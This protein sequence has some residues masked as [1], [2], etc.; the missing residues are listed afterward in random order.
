[1]K[2]IIQ[3]CLIGFIAIATLTACEKEEVVNPIKENEKKAEQFKAS[4]SKEGG[5]VVTKFYA[6]KPI[7]YVTTDD[8]VN[9]E[10]DLNKYIFPH[11]LDDRNVLKPNGTLEIHQNEIKK[12]L[13]DSAVLY[14]TW[15]I[16]SNRNGVFFEFVDEHYSQRRYKLDEFNDAYFI[17]YLDWPVD[18][19]K[20]FSR[21][22]FK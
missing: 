21:F 8:I 5:F 1:M 11:L 13:N 7:D 22:D 20:I 18:G 6:D 9:L 2:L 15:N 19:A 4:V 12:P 16:F 14:R 17:L 10:T 3:F